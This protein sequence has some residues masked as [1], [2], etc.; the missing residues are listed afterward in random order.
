MA[1]ADSLGIAGLDAS[2][3]QWRLK[4]EP[5]IE[6]NRN[7]VENPDD[8]S[9]GV[10]VSRIAIVQYCSQELPELINFNQSR[11][12]L[13]CDGD[14]WITEGFVQRH[15]DFIDITIWRSVNNDGDVFAA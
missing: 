1:P 9:I 12:Q 5:I 7:C 13:T 10:S 15:N 6:I 8:I 4:V 2:D 11:L 14:F 3:L